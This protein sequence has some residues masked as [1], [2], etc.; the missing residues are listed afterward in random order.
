MHKGL[1]NALRV[2]ARVAEL[3]PRPFRFDVYGPEVVPGLG[4]RLRAEARELGLADRF[5]VHGK[6]SA[7]VLREAVRTAELGLFPAE[8]ESFGLSV[9]ETMGAG[10]VPVLQENRAFRYFVDGETGFLADFRQPDEAARVILRAGDLGDDRVRWSASARAKALTYG[11]DGVI[12]QIE[13]VYRRV[14][15]G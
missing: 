5:A 7:E 6:V 4:D 13:E 15:A 11:W 1:G 12:P 9:V 14:I 10:L 8:Y 3:D 2:L